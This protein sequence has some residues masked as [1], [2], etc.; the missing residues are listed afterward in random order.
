MLFTSQLMKI[1]V[2]KMDCLEVQNR[3]IN[4]PKVARM[5]EKASA[6]ILSLVSS[7]VL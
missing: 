7:L 3:H 6:Y 5:Q 2:L 1:A 4:Y